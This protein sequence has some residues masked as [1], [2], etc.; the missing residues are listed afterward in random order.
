M[1]PQSLLP[2]YSLF[3]V[4]YLSLGGFSGDGD[5]H[6]QK[7]IV[8]ICGAVLI[9]TDHVVASGGDQDAGV[10]VRSQRN[11]IA[12]AALAEDFLER[13]AVVIEPGHLDVGGNV[14]A[15]GL[16]DRFGALKAGVHQV[17]AGGGDGALAI[18]GCECAE[19]N[20]DCAAALAVRGELP[21]FIAR[22]AEYGEQ[23]FRGDEQQAA[24]IRPGLTIELLAELAVGHSLIGGPDGHAAVHGDFERSELQPCVAGSG[25]IAGGFDLA[26][27]LFGGTR[28]IES[29]GQHSPHGE[30]ILG[31][32][33]TVQ[34]DVFRG[35]GAVGYG[36]Q[37]GFG[38]AL[39]HAL[40]GLQLLGLAE[41]GIRFYALEQGHC[42]LE[43]SV[44]LAMAILHDLTARWIGRAPRNAAELERGG[45]YDYRVAGIEHHGMIALDVQDFARGHAHFLEPG[46]EGARHDD[47]LTRRGLGG[48]RADV[49][50]DG[51]ER[52]ERRQRLA[53]FAEACGEG[54]H[55]AIDQAG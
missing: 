22:G 26:H 4:H 31:L 44:G 5:P 46:G 11:E 8:G 10:Q 7:W 23:F 27:E 48:A 34:R 2:G 49:G 29:P 1:H 37:T 30:T 6:T 33:L 32:Q 14:Q 35:D 39:E 12:H 28:H 47:P 40:E 43:N 25:R 45:V 51:G 15:L 38:V 19:E 13:G 16:G 41:L 53:E 9:K 17:G 54:V 42:V 36:G 21:T 20:V 52:I 3:G 24:V 55:V 18:E 50:A